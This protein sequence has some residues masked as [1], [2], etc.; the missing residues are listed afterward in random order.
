[1]LLFTSIVM[2]AFLFKWNIAFIWT[3]NHLRLKEFFL[4]PSFFEK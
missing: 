2:N 1:M 4:V 3:N